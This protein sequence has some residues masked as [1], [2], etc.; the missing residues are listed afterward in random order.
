MARDL[1]MYHGE[2]IHSFV[3]WLEE[4][5]FV[6]K[7]YQTKMG[8]PKYEISSRVELVNFFSRFR[9]M[10]KLKLETYVIGTNK[11]EIMQ[12]LNENGG[13]MCLTTA[14]QLH[15]EE[16]F[17]DPE[18]HVYVEDR[19]LFDVLSEQV[20]GRVK[21]SIYEFDLPDMIKEK[22]GIKITSPTRTIMDLFCNNMAYAAEHFIPK[23]WI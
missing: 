6:K 21:V 3:N 22:N 13:I 19:K 20:E 2:K 8:K 16:F 15:G 23:V 5:R 10:Q 1:G 17:R 18:I 14:L 12:L 11:E 4:L 9:D 7:T